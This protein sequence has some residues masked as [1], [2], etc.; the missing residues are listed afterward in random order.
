MAVELQP[1]AAVEPEPPAAVP[2]ALEPEP[3]PMPPPPADWLS[4]AEVFELLGVTA[5]TVAAWRRDGRV[6]QSGRQM[7]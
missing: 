6:W 7:V 2:E 4:S 5:R 3:E 1:V